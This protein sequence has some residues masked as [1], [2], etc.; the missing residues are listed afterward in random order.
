MTHLQKLSPHILLTNQSIFAKVTKN[1]IKENVIIQNVYLYNASPEKFLPY[2][3]KPL[4]ASARLDGYS[5]NRHSLRQL[6]SLRQNFPLV[7]ECLCVVCV[8]VCERERD[9]TH[10]NRSTVRT[11]N[12]FSLFAVTNNNSRTNTRTTLNITYTHSSCVEQLC[13]QMLGERSYSTTEEYAP[14]GVRVGVRVLANSHR[15]GAPSTASNT[16]TTA[17]NITSVENE[18][19]CCCCWGRRFLVF[20]LVFVFVF[21]LVFVL[22]VLVLGLLCFFSVFRCR[23][24]TSDMRAHE[25]FSEQQR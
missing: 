23:A 8:C 13:I 24:A 9:T 20:V 16:S 21:V 4:L 1:G 11:Q 12:P 10:P 19:P 2:N 25:V 15:K 7:C 6:F 17:L 14:N 3:Q 22:L 18:E 5:G